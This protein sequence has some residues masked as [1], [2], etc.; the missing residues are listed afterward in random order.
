MTWFSAA[1]LDPSDWVVP[2]ILRERAERIGDRPFARWESGQATTYA[3]LHADACRA[4]QGLRQIGVERGERV[5]TLMPSSLEA[6]TTWFGVNMLGAVEVTLNTGYRGGPLSH[7]MNLCEAK[8]LVVHRDMLPRIREISGELGHLRSLVIV[9]D[10]AGGAFAA[11]EFDCRPYA[12]LL[13]NTGAAPDLSDL[14]PSDPAVV[15]MTS[16]TTGPAKGV[17]VPHAQCC[18]GALETVIGMAV[19]EDDVLLLLSSVVP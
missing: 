13:D 1:G 3:A 5:A 19:R 11:E 2:R 4:A 7:A 12:A 9:G 14:Q 6:V 15:F 16:G 18:A 8:V 10:D 17:V